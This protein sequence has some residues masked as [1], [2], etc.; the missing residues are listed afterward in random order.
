LSGEAGQAHV[1]TTY[2]WHGAGACKAWY[3]DLNAW[4]KKN[5]AVFD[6]STVEKVRNF[7]ITGDRAYAVLSATFVMKVKDAPQ[8][9]KGILHFRDE[10]GRAGMADYGLDM[11]AGG[12][13]QVI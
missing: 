11:D 7:E 8:S 1:I 10:E 2:E 9:E 3:S 12:T 4:L 6:H 5:D 13:I